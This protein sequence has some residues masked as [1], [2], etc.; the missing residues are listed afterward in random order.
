VEAIAILKWSTVDGVLAGE[1]RSAYD[2]IVS[3]VA[4]DCKRTDIELAI[5]YLSDGF[6][7]NFLH[8]AFKQTDCDFR[9]NNRVH[10]SMSNPLAAQSA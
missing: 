1:L 4:F 5:L 3:C 2:V 9:F 6:F 10:S 7:S 8:H